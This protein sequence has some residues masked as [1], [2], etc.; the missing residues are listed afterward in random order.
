MKIPKEIQV[1]CA[2][3][4]KKIGK[5]GPYLLMRKFKITLDHAIKIIEVLGYG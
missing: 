4:H 5:V 3:W 1:H 2:Y